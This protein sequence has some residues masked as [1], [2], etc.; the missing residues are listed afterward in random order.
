M[1]NLYKVSYIY[2]PI[3]IAHRSNSTKVTLIKLFNG[4]LPQETENPRPQILYHFG[5]EKHWPFYTL[6]SLHKSLFIN[7]AEWFPPLTVYVHP[8]SMH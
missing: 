5:E 1:Y 3:Y 4:K 6:I 2:Y 7:L 8:A